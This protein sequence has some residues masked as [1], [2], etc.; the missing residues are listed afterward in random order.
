MIGET[1][2]GIETV[3]VQS[4]TCTANKFQTQ[5][6]NNVDTYIVTDWYCASSTDSRLQREL[7]QCKFKANWRPNGQAVSYS[8]MQLST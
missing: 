4:A 3:S 7:S 1:Y 6:I 2:L 8:D 5:Q